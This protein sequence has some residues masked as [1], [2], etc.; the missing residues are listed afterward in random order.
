MAGTA[1]AQTSATPFS[2][3][4]HIENFC[5]VDQLKAGGL[6]PSGND[7]RPAVNAN[8]FIA[9]RMVV[10]GTRIVVPA[11]LVIAMPA[12][13]KTPQEIFSQAKGISRTNNESGLALDDKAP[14]LAAYEVS[15]EGNIVCTG[16]GA[17]TYIA[18]LITLSQQALNNG[19]GFIHGFGPGGVIFVGADPR[20]ATPQ[21]GDVRLRINDPKPGDIATG[22]YGLSNEQQ[23]P[24]PLPDARFP[25]PRFQADQGNPTI[26]ALTGYPMCVPRAAADPECPQANRPRPNPALPCHPVTNKCLTTFV[27]DTVALVPPAAFGGT[28]PAC[29]AGCNPRKQAPFVVGDYVTY[30]GTLAH[31][32]PVPAAGARI[33][34]VRIFISVH[35]MVANVGIYTKPGVDPAYVSLEG[36][37]LGTL[38]PIALCGGGGGPP[39]PSPGRGTTAAECQDRIKVEG[40]TTDPSRTVNVYAIHVTPPSSPGAG[41]FVR[42]LNSTAKAQAVFGRFR[43]ITGKFAGVVVLDGAGTTVRGLTREVMVRIDGA[44]GPLPDGTPLPVPP[45]PAVANG[46]TPGVYIAPVSEYI[47]PE[48]TAIQGGVLPRL[49]LQCLEF[50]TNGWSLDGVTTIG[51]LTPWPGDLAAPVSLNCTN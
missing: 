50:L 10:N 12:A 48:P 7:V 36:S 9:A 42:V 37:L 32:G 24:A 11:N 31:D 1:R 27:T 45:S 6:C 26:H 34:P 17:C 22:R 25:D 43:W 5:L 51:Q 13:Y 40:F 41:S 39:P 44:G 20:A 23:F 33:D 49:N 21:P 35:T 46:L 3:V 19:A 8:P 29:G 16:P 38:G 15:I 4:G 18:G 28:I 2:M 47:F 30:A 14:P